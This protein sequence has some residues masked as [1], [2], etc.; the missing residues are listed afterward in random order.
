M[1]K[2]DYFKIVFIILTELYEAMKQGKK[3]DL[4]NIG[5]QRF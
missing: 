3:V 1:A 2:D 5:P 4:F